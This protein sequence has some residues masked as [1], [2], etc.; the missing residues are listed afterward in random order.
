MKWK[1]FKFKYNFI[2]FW[3]TNKKLFD[4]NFRLNSQY[5]LVPPEYRRK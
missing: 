3:L 2:M 5:Q 4:S 1:Y